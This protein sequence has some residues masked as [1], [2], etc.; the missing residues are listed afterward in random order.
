VRIYSKE[1]GNPVEHKTPVE[2]YKDRFSYNNCFSNNLYFRSTMNK[3]FHSTPLYVDAGGFGIV[4]TYS[5]FILNHKLRIVGMIGADVPIESIKEQ[6]QLLDNSL[7]STFLSKNPSIDFCDLE[8]IKTPDF[9]TKYDILTPGDKKRINDFKEGSTNPHIMVT[10]VNRFDFDSDGNPIDQNSSEIDPGK[11]NRIIYSLPLEKK[12]IAF[13]IFDKKKLKWQNILYASFWGLFLIAFSLLIFFVY[14]QMKKRI[15]EEEKK[16]DLITHMHSSYVITDKSNH[17][18]ACNE[19]FENLAGDKN[20]IGKDFKVY[21]TKDS[22]KDL[23]FFM[24]SGKER[25][26]CPV[27]IKTKSGN[28]KSTILINSQ[29]SY[30]LDNK[31]RISILIRSENIEAALAEKYA[32]RISHVLKSPLHSILQISDQLRRKTAQPRYEDY[33]R[34]LDVE[35][36]GLKREI[37]RLLSM[38][39]MEI[40]S[41][42]PEHKKFDLTKLVKEIKREYVPLV[43]KRKLGFNSNFAEGV[44]IVGDRNMIKV[45]IENILDNA[46]KYTPNGSISFYLYDSPGNVKIV[47]GD[48]GIGIPPDE[49]GLI[50]RKNYRGK[51][52]VVKDSPGKGIGLYHCRNLINLHEGKIDAKSEVGK[53]SEFTIL[54][55]K[56]LKETKGE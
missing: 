41:S 28:E 15:Q 33:F 27:V 32:D 18:K 13:F 47:I 20:V 52:P 29:T 55:P 8:E 37:S 12:R 56:N 40:K 44:S 22:I 21:L 25:F 36:S 53:G 16:L 34:I 31:A 46:S 11:I 3:T 1:T 14:G 7:S 26:E 54:I 10:R 38:L 50:F 43:E 39:K 19:E 48:T 2:N 5:T 17:I 6:E 42:K 51:H 24:D 30:H 49:I 35:I 45:T 4:R 9:K 23:K